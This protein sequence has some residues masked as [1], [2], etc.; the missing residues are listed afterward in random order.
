MMEEEFKNYKITI[1]EQNLVTSMISQFDQ[2]LIK[3]QQNDQNT[4]ACCFTDGK[5][6]IFGKENCE[7]F[8]LK[9][10][11]TD[12]VT[13]LLWFDQNHLLCSQDKVIH[14]F[15][16]EKKQSIVELQ[17]HSQT[18][19]CVCKNFYNNLIA[20]AGQDN[21]IMMWDIRQKKPIN[22]ILAHSRSITSLQFSKDSMN[23]V[24]CGAD[25]F[26]R[27]FSTHTGLCRCTL[28]SDTTSVPAFVKFADNNQ[29]LLVDTLA[30]KIQLWDW[31]Q[32]ELR[33]V[34]T[35]IQNDKAYL[36]SF[37]IR[38]KYSNKQRFILGFSENNQIIVW[39][40]L[41]GKILKNQKIKSDTS[42][43]LYQKDGLQSNG[44]Y[45][46]GN[47]THEMFQYSIDISLT[48]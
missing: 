9:P 46:Y 6:E 25:G 48:D 19:F 4:I 32:Q 8:D 10:D 27:V 23:V 45:L 40:L 43:K 39:D 16:I 14:I 38:D 35:G 44:F 31:H 13:D 24:S 34:Y 36:E 3:I 1:Q 7:N 5:V 2:K 37:M 33:Q 12:A 41:T 20:S 22:L 11:V 30:N 42:L 29:F 28:N 17:G 18:I 47:D 21:T 15:D 26:T